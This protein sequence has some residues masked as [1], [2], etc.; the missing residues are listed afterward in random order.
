MVEII[1]KD[2]VALIFDFDDTLAPDSTTKLLKHHGIDTVSFWQKEHKALLAEG[3]DSST[4]WLKLFLGLIGP[5]KP[6]GNLTNKK[7]RE[8][9]ASL[10]G[11]FY[12]GLPGFFDDVREKITA[13]GFK[14]IE[15]E[16]YIISGG[17]YEVLMGSSVVRKYFKA[18]YGCHLGADT[19]DGVL[20]YVKRVI[21]FTEK[22]RYIFEIQKGIKPEDTWTD[23]NLVNKFAPGESRRIPLKN[24]IYVGDGL[25]DIPCFSLIKQN[26]GKS[27]GVFDAKSD[28]KAK[29]ALEQ[30]LQTARV[31][32][33]HS[34][35]YSDG[36]D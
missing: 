25:T 15:I 14:N 26:G 10:D 20:K 11:D 36:Q 35:N 33:M 4:A 16:F 17:L 24:M 28:K 1:R 9:G 13:H 7:L 6:L 5:D 12:A 29:D 8:F 32:S 3:Y 34:P 30:F 18:V 31:L 22:T 19:P 2:V 21:N 23:P 27:F